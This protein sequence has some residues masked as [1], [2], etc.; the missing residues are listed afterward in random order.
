MCTDER[1]NVTL[2]SVSSYLCITFWTLLINISIKRFL[3]RCNFE[4]LEAKL[5]EHTMLIQI[6]FVSYI[7]ILHILQEVRIVQED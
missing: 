6:F 2:P 5:F 3:Q 7:N 1:A 4:Q